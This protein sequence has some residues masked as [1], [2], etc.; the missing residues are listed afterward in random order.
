MKGNNSLSAFLAMLS[1]PAPVSAETVNWDGGG[2]DMNWTTG[3]N[4][5]NDIEPGEGDDVTIGEGFAVSYDRFEESLPG[6][7]TLDIAGTLDQTGGVIRTNGAKINVATTGSLSGS[8]FWDFNDSE[9]TF[10][11]GASATMEAWENKG[12]NVFNFKLGATGF[13]TLTPNRFFIGGGATIA[14]A[15]YNVD[16]TDYTGDGGA[17]TLVDY[18]A[19]ATGMTDLIFQGAGGLNVI[20]PGSFPDAALHWNEG[21]KSIVLVLKPKTWDGEAADNSWGSA[22]NWD[23]DGV[24]DAG[25]QV[26]VGSNAAVTGATNVF[27]SL[28]IEAGTSVTLDATTDLWQNNLRIDGTL[29]KAGVLR[30]GGTGGGSNI[31]ISGSLGPSM[32]FLDTQNATI[33][34]IDGA[35]FANPG[36][37][38]EHKGTNTFGYTLSPTGFTTLMA[39]GLFSGN[40][41]SWSDVTYNIDVSNY[42]INNGTVVTLAD[43]TSTTM[44]GDFANATVNVMTGDSGLD[45]TLSFD[46]VEVR[47]VLKFEAPPG[48]FA[49]TEIDY[50]PDAATVTLTWRTTSAEVYAAFVSTDLKDWGTDLNDDLSLANDENPDD[51]DL[52]TVTFDLADLSLADKEKL[53]FRIE[54]G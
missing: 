6:L 49:I 37:H 16:M 26:V 34:F 28:T 11:D 29:D 22:T 41:A 39:G 51:G 8:G 45:A 23:P 18:H 5:S 20:N 14:D 42:D 3:L 24:P 52:I 12:M 40:N 46:P 47:L 44:V 38:F 7:M 19:D 25:E 43:Y 4:W 21:A 31:E 10:A 17:I 1:I 53:F 54:E 15:T 48:L 2:A 33:N 30:I 50:N 9:I 27:S 13:K 36:L 32:T 35:S